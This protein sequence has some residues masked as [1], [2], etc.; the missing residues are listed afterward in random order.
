ML[1][2]TLN[3]IPFFEFELFQ[4][5]RGSLRHAVFTRQTDIDDIAEIQKV[6]QTSAPPLSF[7][8]QLHGIKIAVVENNRAE[9][10]GDVLITS[11]SEIPLF[12]RIADCASIMIFDPEKKVIANIHAGWRGLAAEIIR[13]TINRLCAQ[14][15]SQRQNLL[16]GISPMIGPCCYR[17]SDPAQELPSHFHR[18]IA[19]KNKVN[20]WAAAEGH[21]RECGIL[22]A[23]IENSR[24]CTACNP[25]D[26]YSHRRE[27]DAGRFGTAIM[28]C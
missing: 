2:K 4:E 16:V 13:K 5:F 1:K 8:N 25:E 12:I 9:R 26:F 17:F 15:N 23:H 14:F 7:K 11:K 18:F 21:L 6:L 19:K 20:L 27:G 10:N 3:G 28:L 24:M 22:H